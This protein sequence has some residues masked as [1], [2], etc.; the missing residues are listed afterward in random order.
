MQHK[1]RVCSLFGL[2]GCLR[3]FPLQRSTTFGNA[4]IWAFM[5]PGSFLASAWHDLWH[6]SIFGPFR[7]LR[8]FP[9]QRGIDLGI[10]T[11][12][13]FPLL[14]TLPASA[15]YRLSDHS[16]FWASRLS[17]SLP[18]SARY[19]LSACSYLGISVLSGLSR[20][21]TIRTRGFLLIGTHLKMLIPLAL[22]RL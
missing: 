17:R 1:L 6:C 9:L 20:F 13:S 16:H 21:C 11:I 7:Y 22:T 12:W 15:R 2:F 5:L 18:A 3:P 10:A 4:T 8:G 19:E 14:L